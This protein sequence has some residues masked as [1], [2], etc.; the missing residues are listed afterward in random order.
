MSRVLALQASHTFEHG[1]G[2][3]RVYCT[4]FGLAIFLYAKNIKNLG[5]IG[6]PVRVFIWMTLLPAMNASGAGRHVLASTN[7]SNSY[8]G[9]G[10]VCVFAH[11]CVR[12]V[13]A[14]YD[15]N[16]WPR[17]IMGTDVTRH[18][19]PKTE[20]RRLYLMKARWGIQCNISRRFR[21][22]L[23]AKISDYFL[24]KAYCFE[25]LQ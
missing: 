24:S 9:D 23:S 22:I 5:E 3:N 21:Y 18:V 12:G 8:G 10:G 25:A 13:F 1:G 20:V 19:V 4:Q 15:N 7:I 16:I 11:A 2:V 6:W 17:L 14:I